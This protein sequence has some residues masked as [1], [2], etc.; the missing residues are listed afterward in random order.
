MCVSPLS[1][2]WSEARTAEVKNMAQLGMF[3]VR[4]RSSAPPGTTIHRG[5]WVLQIK[6]NG[7][8]EIRWCALGFMGVPGS[9]IPSDTFSPVAAPLT[10]RLLTSVA[11]EHDL[12]MC[13]TDVSDAFQRT[14]S[15]KPTWCEPP[16]D[17]PRTD[18]TTGEPPV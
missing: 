7:R 2:L 12:D 3:S 4:L 11:A 13:T 14:R 10:A 1:A 17:E 9:D 16:P 8:L 15:R 6:R 18:P 5:R